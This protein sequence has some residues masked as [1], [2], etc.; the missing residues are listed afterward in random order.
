MTRG[1]RV[2]KRSFEVSCP[3]CG[4]V[5]LIEDRNNPDLTEVCPNCQTVFLPVIPVDERSDLPSISGSDAIEG[6]EDFD[7][8]DDEFRILGI[9]AFPLIVT[10][11]C[12]VFLLAA[13]IS[14]LLSSGRKEAVHGESLSADPSVLESDI[15]VDVPQTLSDRSD[16]EDRPSSNSE[17]SAVSG[18]YDTVDAEIGTLPDDPDFLEE[19]RYDDFAFPDQIG[20]KNDDLDLATDDEE[21]VLIEESAEAYKPQ[22]ASETLSDVHEDLRD[23]AVDPV[24]TEDSQSHSEE[25][26]NENANDGESFD[27]TTNADSDVTV[28]FSAMTRS[29]NDP[30]NLEQRLNLNIRQVRLAQAGLADFIRLFYQLT[31]VP[32]QLDWRDF[33]SP[34]VTWEKRTPYEAANLT[35]SQFINEFATS[36]HLEVVMGEDRVILTDPSIKND[37]PGKVIFD[38][39]DLIGDDFESESSPFSADKGTESFFPEQ[40][41]LSIL[42]SAFRDLVLD[43]TLL[44]SEKSPILERG[45][46]QKSLVLSA[47]RKTIEKAYVFF[48]RLRSLRHLPQKRIVEAEILIPETLCWENR[49]SNPISISFLRAVP[50]SEALILIEREYQIRFFF[51]YAAIPGGGEVLETP[52]RLIVKE[53][54]LEQVL[55]EL[56]SPLGLKFVVLTEDLLAVTSSGAGEEFD[57]EI[58]FYATP[59]E[60]I[61]LD[62]AAALADR[63]RKSVAPESWQTDSRSGGMIWIDPFSHSF[64]IRQT[65]ANQIKVRRFLQ[66]GLVGKEISL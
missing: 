27:V 43:Q 18:E 60:D 62:E 12:I 59:E 66:S 32:V 36:F 49:L 22:T 53:Q 28:L 6:A 51:D 64:Y 33:P 45:T 56:L 46:D 34:V 23:T 20:E 48:D 40:L 38:C 30:I 3:H 13:V 57:A 26:R 50:L 41:S 65:I 7:R 55:S 63:I 4:S 52:V 10:L 16:E 21:T 24:Q 39:S 5:L 47:D 1:D 29:S 9:P 42:E 44:P 19:N 54:P 35:A 8:P 15:S 14:F 2:E 11:A 37:I 31:G 61:S 58:H 17:I 25:N